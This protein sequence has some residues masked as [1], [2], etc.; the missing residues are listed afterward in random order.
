MSTNTWSHYLCNLFYCRLNNGCFSFR[1]RRSRFSAETCKVQKSA[2]GAFLGSGRSRTKQKTKQGLKDFVFY[3]RMVESELTSFVYRWDQQ[4]QMHHMNAIQTHLKKK[5]GEPLSN[6]LLFCHRK[7]IK[8]ISRT[9]TL[10]VS[11]AFRQF[12]FTSNWHSS[13]QI[14]HSSKRAWRFRNQTEHPPNW[15]QLASS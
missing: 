12:I 13:N 2:S 5:N 11:A 1:W 9:Q 14:W 15:N 3:Y 7:A 8:C 10:K 6:H 4:M